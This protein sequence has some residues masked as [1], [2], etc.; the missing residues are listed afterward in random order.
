MN[1]TGLAKTPV[2]QVLTSQVGKTW[3][4]RGLNGKTRFKSGKISAVSLNMVKLVNLFEN[5]CRRQWLLPY[6]LK[7]ASTATNFCCH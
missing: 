3:F 7:F 4:K 6:A 5:S 2:K 1:V